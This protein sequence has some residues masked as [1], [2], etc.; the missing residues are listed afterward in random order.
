[1]IIIRDTREQDPIA[2]NAGGDIEQVVVQKLPVGDYGCKLSADSPILPLVFERKGIA[3]LWQT[4][5]VD[6]TRF[7]AEV[8]RARES[9]ITLYLAI[10]GTMRDVYAGTSFSTVLG[11]QI[12]RT[13]FMFKVRYGVEPIFCAS[14][15][16]MKYYMLETFDACRR[17]YLKHGDTVPVQDYMETPE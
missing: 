10:E 9:S 6:I 14:R 2:I 11:S 1:M 5:T 12:V 15:D 8:E 17:N 13:I 7:K 4:L 16:E 3:D